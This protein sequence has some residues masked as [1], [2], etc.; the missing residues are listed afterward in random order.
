MKETGEKLA[1]IRNWHEKREGKLEGRFF[2]CY[3]C[4]DNKSDS[5]LK[6]GKEL[7]R[8]RLAM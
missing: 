5:F 6:K 1:R 8:E 7:L 4:F 2:C 3:G